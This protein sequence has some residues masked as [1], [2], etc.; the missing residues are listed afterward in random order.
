MVQVQYPGTGG[1]GKP[2][3][4]RWSQAKKSMSAGGPD[5]IRSGYQQISLKSKLC[6]SEPSSGT[7]TH[8]C[9]KQSRFHPNPTKYCTHSL[10]QCFQH[11]KNQGPSLSLSTR[12]IIINVDIVRKQVLQSVDVCSDCGLL[13]TNVFPGNCRCLDACELQG[14]SLGGHYQNVCCFVQTLKIMFASR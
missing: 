5:Q 3:G 11:R 6:T 4:P 2:G 12:K 8:N 9:V 7:H 10:L 14:P 13:F 1:E